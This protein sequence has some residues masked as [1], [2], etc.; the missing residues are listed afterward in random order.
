MFI[1][2]N[3]LLLVYAFHKKSREL[4]EKDKNVIRRR[5]KGISI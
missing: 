4:Q 1:S 2:K 3:S 5:I